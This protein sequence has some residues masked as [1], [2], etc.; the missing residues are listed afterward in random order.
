[1]GKE[2][3][4]KSETRENIVSE[5]LQKSPTTLTEEEKQ[6]EIITVALRWI[7][8]CEELRQDEKLPPLT[9]K[10]CIRDC[11]EKKPRMQKQIMKK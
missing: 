9:E 11:V 5:P 3:S 1:M 6:N 10:T 8:K 4:N 2:N 7:E